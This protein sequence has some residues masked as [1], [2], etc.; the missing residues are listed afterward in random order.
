MR[1]SEQLGFTL[2]EAV[3]VITLTG[4]VAGI[5]AVF[6]VA[7]VKSYLAGSARAQLVDQAD[8]ALRRIG[9]DIAVAL[10]NSVRTLSSAGS[11]S[12][13]LIPSSGA[14]RYATEGAGRL[15]FGA[16][17]NA[18][19]LLGPALALASTQQL[20][21]YNLGADNPDADAYAGANRRS[22]SN[23]AGIA[24]SITMANGAGLPVSLAA[25][26]Y[27]VFAV[28]QPVSYRCDLAAATLT[29]Y[30]GYGFVAAQPDPPAGGSAALLARGVKACTFSYSA[31]AAAT[32]TALVTLRLT[33]ASAASGGDS[34]TITLHHALHV[35]NQP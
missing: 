30:S 15:D 31:A 26:P 16:A 25:P 5:V 18:F 6:I 7:P 9:R 27:R 28:E 21:F 1:R 13:E 29:R 10:P 32:R 22:A 12:L 23:G 33:L 2:V 4:I 14:A 20:V 34:E 35:D 8:Q 17:D 24:S 3:L 11:A 19:D